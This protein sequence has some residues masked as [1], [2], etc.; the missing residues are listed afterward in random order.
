[1]NSPGFGAAELATL[2]AGGGGAGGAAGLGGK[3]S[4]D[5]WGGAEPASN[6]RRN[7]AVALSG[8]ASAGGFGPELKSLSFIVWQVLF[9][10]QQRSQRSLHAPDCRVKSLTHKEQ[11]INLRTVPGKRYPFH[12]AGVRCGMEQ[13]G[14]GSECQ[15][16]VVPVDRRSFSLGFVL[17]RY[18]LIGFRPSLF[19]FAVGRTDSARFRGIPQRKRG[20]QK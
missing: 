9:G 17:L 7:M 19:A 8:S 10:S 20:Q 6:E 14:S 3:N 15:F 2:G 18:A 1:M 11:R 16:P 4:E 13:D 12:R 5:S